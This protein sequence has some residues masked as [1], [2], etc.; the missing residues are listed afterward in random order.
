MGIFGIPLN[1]FH[2][3]GGIIYIVILSSIVIGALFWGFS[4]LHNSS[5]PKNK[6]KK[7]KKGKN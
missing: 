1:K 3:L 5:L 7:S 4:Q 2:S 6:K